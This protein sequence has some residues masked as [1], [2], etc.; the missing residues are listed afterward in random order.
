M[1]IG[2]FKPILRKMQ[3][4]PLATAFVV[5]AMV[6]AALFWLGIAYYAAA[7]TA[8]P[9]K[10]RL[11]DAISGEDAQ[12]ETRHSIPLT[13]ID[14][15]PATATEEPPPEET[16]YYGAANSIAS[17]PDSDEAETEKPKMDGQEER[18]IRFADSDR[19]NPVPLQ[20]ADPPD[21]P[22]PDP[23]DTIPEESKSLPPGYH[24]QGDPDPL[25][26]QDDSV[27]KILASV[28]PPPKRERPR[29]LAMARNQD[30]SRPGRKSKQ[31]GGVSH[32][33]RLSFPVA[34]TQF[35]SYDA[36]LIRAVEARWFTL[37]DSTPFVQRSGKVVVEFRLNV[38]GRITDI[39]TSENEVGEILALLCQRA[40]MDPAPYGEWPRDMR[41]AI[42]ATYRDVTFTFYYN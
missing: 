1:V 28:P 21:A 26:K 39:K 29:T 36:R 12:N 38:D 7:L 37:L 30:T 14:V 31:E 25:A 33:G 13:F 18:M 24:A 19:P 10:S 22:E 4:H 27:A 9:L 6:H 11:A 20:P 42:G 34:A 8:A 35:G 5:S 40:I 16:K 41:S 2:D 3:R 17:N 15:D 32:R 23:A